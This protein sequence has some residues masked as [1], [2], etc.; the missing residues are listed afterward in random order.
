MYITYLAQLNL[1][2]RSKVTVHECNYHFKRIGTVKKIGIHLLY[3]DQHGN[4]TSLPGLID[5][6]YTPFPEELDRSDSLFL[7]ELSDGN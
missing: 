3:S 1:L 5:Y 7:Q 2:L 4:A 6:S